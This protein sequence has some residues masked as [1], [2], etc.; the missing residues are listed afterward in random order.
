[1]G[2]F[3]ESTVMYQNV[4]IFKA[5]GLIFG[6]LLIIVFANYRAACSRKDPIE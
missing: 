5:Y 3:I 2:D 4:D 1:M 6:T